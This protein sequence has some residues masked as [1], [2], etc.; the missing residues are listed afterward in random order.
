LLKDEPS[1]LLRGK[2]EVRAGSSRVHAE[3]AL[4][5]DAGCPG[6]DL[7]IV[8]TRGNAHKLQLVNAPVLFGRM[9]RSTATI[10]NG[11]KVRLTQLTP[12]V[13]VLV[14]LYKPGTEDV[15]SVRTAR[16]TVWAMEDSTPAAR[17]RTSVSLGAQP[18]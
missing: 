11:G 15:T 10:A 5:I 12:Q 16:L 3:V 17:R 18:L 6:S 8:T 2:L 4:L 1:G 14:P 9:V 13:D 7:D